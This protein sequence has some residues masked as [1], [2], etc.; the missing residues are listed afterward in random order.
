MLANTFTQARPL[1]NEA[2]TLH[3]CD[4]A[5]SG[6]DNGCYTTAKQR[7]VVLL[8]WMRHTGREL[9]FNSSPTVFYSLKI[10]KGSKGF[11]TEKQLSAFPLVH[12]T[13]YERELFVLLSSRWRGQTEHVSFR[14]SA[15]HSAAAQSAAFAAFS[16]N[17][18]PSFKSMSLLDSGYVKKKSKAK[19]KNKTNTAE[20]TEP[21]VATGLVCKVCAVVVLPPT[22][23][24]PASSCWRRLSTN[25]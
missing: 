3:Q 7:R 12:E 17:I 15:L 10:K 21:L 23:T 25:L 11:P 8:L 18:S 2:L 22:L 14:S 4:T 6:S 20:Y 24:Q 9:Q 19:K 1:A 16:L 5:D 13:K